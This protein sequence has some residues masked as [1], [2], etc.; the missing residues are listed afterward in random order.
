MTITLV[1]I[2]AK[3]AKSLT[4]IVRTTDF[5]HRSVWKQSNKFIL[6]VLLISFQSASHSPNL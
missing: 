4:E 5:L 2:P 6:T 1:I 3:T